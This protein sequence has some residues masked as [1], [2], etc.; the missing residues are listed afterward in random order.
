MTKTA[1]PKTRKGI[2][3]I[4]AARGGLPRRLASA[5]LPRI[6]SGASA[7]RVP[8]LLRSGLDAAQ[9]ALA[10]AGSGGRLIWKSF[11]VL[12]LAPT[13]LFWSYAA[14]WQSERFVAEARITVRAAQEQRGALTDA[15][16]LIGKLS[17]G[18][19]ST[20]QDSYIVLN[21][22][23]SRAVVLDIGGRD[24]LEEKFSGGGIDYFSRLKRGVNVEE[25]WKFWTSH[26]A[27]SVD[28]V[29][30]ILTLRVDA[31]QPRDAVLLADDIVRL[32]EA[33][34]NKITLRNRG[35]ALG[36][37]ELEV[38]LSGQK[39]ADARENLLQFRN[40]NV[41]IDPGSRAASLGEMIGKLTLE[42]IDIEN[43]LTT[44]SSTLSS[45]APSQRLQRT[46]L[47]VIDQQIVEL[48]K[49]L[50]DSHSGDAVSAQIAAYERLKL[51]QQFAEKLY[52]IAQASYQKARQELE[53]QQLYLVLAVRP[54]LPETAF[55]PKVTADTLLLFGALTALWAV[56]TLIVA[57]IND[58]MG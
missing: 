30:G 22:I 11:A 42:R 1:P 2:G 33:L 8:A 45:D 31:F 57:S 19:K 49:K 56:G 6:L 7:Q 21:Y 16:S 47:A 48:K 5:R 12:V 25:L 54:T 26:V 18:A 9:D 14:F 38:S 46:R 3:L 51:D 13:F 20:F 41:I 17:G 27:A 29:S 39:L 52:T 58:H 37:A 40:Q 15:F 55:Y 35:D 10:A 43:A 24:Y 44:F 34:V 32:S 53:K 28:T 36:R 23:K 4:A 50:T